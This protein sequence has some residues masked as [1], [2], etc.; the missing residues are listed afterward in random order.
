MNRFIKFPSFA[1]SQLLLTIFA[2]VS[3]SFAAA[4]A[5]P[6]KQAAKLALAVKDVTAWPNLTLLRDG[7]FIATIFN[8]PSHGQVEGDV[9]CWATKDGGVSWKL[10][11]T[12]ACHEPD[13]NRMN[14]AV[15]L[16]KN[17]DLIVISSGWHDKPQAGQETLYNGPF[18][19]AIAQPWVSRSRDGGKTWEVSKAAFPLR[20]PDKGLL[21]PYGDIET[22][23]NGDLLAAAYSAK[24]P[25]GQDRVY[26]YRSADDGHTWGSPV[27][28]D[29]A[30]ERC[31]ETAFL[32]L[33]DGKWL[34]VARVN[35]KGLRLY[36][37]DDDG[38]NWKFSKWV[39]S[40]PLYPAHI[41]RLKDGRLLITYGNRT[42]NKGIDA[43]FSNDGGNTWTKPKRLV[44][45]EG[46]GGY[47]ASIQRPDGMV[48]TVFY[49]KKTQVY[50]GYQMA[51]LVWD[52]AA[53]DQKK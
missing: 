42:S 39:A 5:H 30:A 44:G 29:A 38:R 13:A 34:A 46:D 24:G 25:S 31:N 10:A 52:P 41:T 9:D 2:M 19:A 23:A 49:A 45:F 48:L 6:G 50:D 53:P 32:H 22:A 7:T 1:A 33:G 20:A 16:A 27:A 18:R 4:S 21:I 28:L 35:R 40:G 17:G 14:V 8:K 26:I 37:S 47:P 36:T 12:P 3:T 43:I 15:G 51:T 11:G